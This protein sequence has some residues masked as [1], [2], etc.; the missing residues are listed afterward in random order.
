MIA[1]S[2]CKRRKPKPGNTP[3]IPQCNGSCHQA[4]GSFGGLGGWL[5]HCA[6]VAGPF[7]DFSTRSARLRNVSA[8][9]RIAE[10]DS[11]RTCGMT[12]SFT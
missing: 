1:A 4:R 12:A 9:V 8:T 6:L 7:D 2:N 5:G 11:L 3:D 10:I